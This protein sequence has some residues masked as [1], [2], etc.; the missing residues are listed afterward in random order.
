MSR[1]KPLT[2][3]VNQ[4]WLTKSEIR[5]LFKC[6]YNRANE[7]FNAAAEV[8]ENEVMFRPF[9]YRVRTKTVLSLLGI[10]EEEMKKSVLPD[11]QS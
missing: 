4:P 6:G 1:L 2:E 10:T 5:K 7:I 8:D 11:A 9:D 3:V